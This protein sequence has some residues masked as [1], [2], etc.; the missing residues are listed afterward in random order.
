V[1]QSC[2][3]ARPRWPSSAMVLK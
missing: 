2:S 1:R 3:A